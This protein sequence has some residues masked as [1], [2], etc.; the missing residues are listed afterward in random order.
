MPFK[1]LFSSHKKNKQPPEAGVHSPTER[2]DEAS[3]EL[4]DGGRVMNETRQKKLN[5]KKSMGKADG[6]TSIKRKHSK[7]GNGEARTRGHD[8]TAPLCRA[9]TAPLPVSSDPNN[10]SGRCSRRV[11]KSSSV[12]ASLNA[13]ELLHGKR[14]R[15]LA[16]LGE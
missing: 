11:R 6:G 10:G 15:E 7:N 1:T 3:M 14:L 16:Q 4:P 5:K 9:A 12:G 8:G 2:Q 13:S